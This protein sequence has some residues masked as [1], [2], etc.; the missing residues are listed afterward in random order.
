MLASMAT[1]SERIDLAIRQVL[2]GGE[3]P[4]MVNRW[5]VLVE[6]IDADGERLV[7]FDTSPGMSAWDSKGLLTHALD[8]ERAATIREVLRRD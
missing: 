6:M 5:V 7:W 3:Q 2:E 8:E 4:T 1:N